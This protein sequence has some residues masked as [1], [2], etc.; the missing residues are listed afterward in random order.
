MLSHET[1]LNSSKTTSELPNRSHS[2]KKEADKSAPNI[3]NSIDGREAGN[4][5]VTP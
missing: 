5:A 3:K 4:P 1:P 2:Q